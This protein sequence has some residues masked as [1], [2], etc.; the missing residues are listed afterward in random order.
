MTRICI[1]TVLVAC[2]QNGT[3]QVAPHWP[4]SRTLCA[5]FVAPFTAPSPDVATRR[6]CVHSVLKMAAVEE[7][8]KVYN[9]RKVAYRKQV[10]DLLSTYS[11]VLIV[12][13]DNVTSM[14]MHEIRIA[15]RGKATIL[16]GKNVSLFARL[17]R[18]LTLGALTLIALD[19]HRP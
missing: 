1:S 12:D 13:A 8:T 15:L 6:V 7:V 9:A 4:E 14:Q 10:E 17:P 11:K 19:S 16:M 5:R 18:P 2:K 3:R